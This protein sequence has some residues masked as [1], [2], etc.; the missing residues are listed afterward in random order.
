MIFP[1]M[2]YNDSYGVVMSQKI[3]GLEASVN[4]AITKG[5]IPLG[6]P[7][8]SLMDNIPYWNQMMFKPDAKT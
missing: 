8:Q 7:F 4:L 2:D 3:G 1:E 6:G 5:Y